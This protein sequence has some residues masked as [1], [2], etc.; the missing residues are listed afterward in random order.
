[1][2]VIL[3]GLVQ[4]VTLG[5]IFFGF[6]VWVYIYGLRPNYW[7]FTVYLYTKTISQLKKAKIATPRKLLVF[8]DV[9]GWRRTFFKLLKIRL[10]LFFYN[11]KFLLWLCS[12]Y[13]CLRST[14]D[15]KLANFE[16][17]V[18]HTASPRDIFQ[19]LEINC[20]IVC[21]SNVSDLMCIYCHYRRLRAHYS[22]DMSRFHQI[23]DFIIFRHPGTFMVVQNKKSCLAT[24]MSIKISFQSYHYKHLVT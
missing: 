8:C 22:L 15:F 13:K 14:F 21:N 18:H 19:N 7:N 2:G 4:C 24:I 12:H 10:N 1:M 16:I 5:H 6:L 3:V 23:Y 9:P 11:V 17:S 20:K